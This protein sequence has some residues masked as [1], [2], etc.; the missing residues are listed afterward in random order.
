MP[1]KPGVKLLSVSPPSREWPLSPATLAIS[2]TYVLKLT[3]SRKNQKRL[4]RSLADYSY[5]TN[6]FV[7]GHGRCV[8]H[9]SAYF[10][11]PY[12]SQ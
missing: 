12:Q 7:G 3:S 8:D 1:N 9:S 11:K 10:T 6:F 2:K 4:P 5:L